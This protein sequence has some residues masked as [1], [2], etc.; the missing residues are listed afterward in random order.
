MRAV[1]APARP[2]RRAG[3]AV[4]VLAALVL[5]SLGG[6][7][8]AAALPTTASETSVGVSRASGDGSGGL[9]AP[10]GSFAPV[11]GRPA[12]PPLGVPFESLNLSG[13]PRSRSTGGMSPAS[14]PTGRTSPSLS[15]TGALGR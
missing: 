3:R 15:S 13:A 4:F 14:S 6:S 9:S 5:A 7:V 12:D 10:F 8:V 1:A 2:A 11:A